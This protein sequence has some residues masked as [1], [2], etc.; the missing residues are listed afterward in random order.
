MDGA[1]ERKTRSREQNSVCMNLEREKINKKERNKKRGGNC[2]GGGKGRD[3]I[4]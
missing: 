3:I 4:L 1:L 2:I